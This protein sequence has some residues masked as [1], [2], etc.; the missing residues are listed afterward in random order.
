[1]IQL[2]F[3]L[4]LQFY[5][6][7]ENVIIQMSYFSETVRQQP[8]IDASDRWDSAPT[9]QDPNYVTYTLPQGTNKELERI[10]TLFNRC[11]CVSHSGLK[12]E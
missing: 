4:L 2:L 5:V 10:R 11:I 9:M 3:I 12:P 8:I 1:M 6:V 7:K